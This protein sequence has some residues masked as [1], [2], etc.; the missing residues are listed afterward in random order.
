VLSDVRQQD[1]KFL[2][3]ERPNEIGENVTRL[4]NMTMM[5]ADD[6]DSDDDSKDVERSAQYRYDMCRKTA[7]YDRHVNTSFKD[8]G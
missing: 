3:K 4:N 7:N 5:E 2:G 8:T 6:K 1:S